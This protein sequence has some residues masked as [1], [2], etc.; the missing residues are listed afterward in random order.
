MFTRF[1]PT[2]KLIAQ[3][4]PVLFAAG[5]A[6]AAPTVENFD[7]KMG[8]EEYSLPGNEK[9]GMG[10]IGVRKAMTPNFRMG[11]E[12]YTAMTGERGGFITI[13]VN[14]E[15][16]LPL[17]PNWDLEFGLFIGAG[18]GKGGA[19]LAGGGLMLRENLGLGYKLGNLGKLSF[20][21]SQV[22]FPENG[23][24]SSTQAYL[25]YSY[26]FS[27][28]FESG[29]DG[30]AHW[31]TKR[32]EID[33]TTKR[34][35]VSAVARQLRIS[36]NTRTDTC[37][38]QADFATL[39]VEWRTYLDDY[40][41]L[42]AE[43]SAAMNGNSAGY[44]QILA[45]GG[46]RFPLSN[47]LALSTAL[48]F[49]G[50]GGGGVDM[51]GGF[52]WD[53]ALALQYR[54]TDQWFIDLG[55]DYLTAPSG[56]FK[57]MAASARIGYQFG[58][59]ADRHHFANFEHTWTGHPI[60]LR[61]A[62]QQYT[63]N[64]SNWRN[65][66]EQDVGNLGVQ[67]DYF[68]TPNWYLTGQ[69]LGAYKG[70]AGAYMTGLMGLGGHLPIGRTGLFVEGEALLGAAGG[71]GLAV[72]SGLVYQGNIGLGYQ[73][74]PALSLMGSVGAIKSA[75]GNFNANVAGVSLGYQF[76]LFSPTN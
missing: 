40:R 28:L 75:D 3:I 17:T 41:F 29:F 1:A 76:R 10:S 42:K 68:L 44:M 60:R 33:F 51:A 13:G 31:S 52:M 54:L 35:E 15:Y 69:G 49:G 64:A 65:K 62:E 12:G 26:R 59:D 63:G 7:I 36:N 32:R 23:K 61:W 30:P 8:F 55:A 46:F 2:K 50:G 73:L 56:S 6:G 20:G 66:P 37:T 19:Q 22:D 72:G 11:V 71:G 38:H 5:N 4:L 70:E 24:I 27:G 43:T 45:G 58:L 53:A 14:G 47:S 34:H 39:G 21:V 48:T 16:A 74:T 18:G 67:V 57:T 9:M 25:G